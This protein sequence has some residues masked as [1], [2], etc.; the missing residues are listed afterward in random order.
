MSF[1]GSL[2]APTTNTARAN[3][4]YVFVDG[5][6]G[7]FGYARHPHILTQT[8]GI[9]QRD[10]HFYTFSAASPLF[11]PRGQVFTVLQNS[12]FSARCS[13]TSRANEICARMYRTM[14]HADRNA[15]GNLV[16]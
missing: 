12:R 3:Q 5:T 7:A 14:M 15:Q 1:R 9:I 2:S 6:I 4:F 13:N 10:L 16:G 11:T 8:S